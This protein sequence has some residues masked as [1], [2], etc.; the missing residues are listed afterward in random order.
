MRLILSFLILIFALADPAL[1]Y[2]GPGMGLGFIGSL[3]GMIA[4]VF[5]AIFGFIWYPIKRMVKNKRSA[6][7]ADDDDTN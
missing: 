2:V 4:A 7:T 3:L 1:A 5:V 6:K